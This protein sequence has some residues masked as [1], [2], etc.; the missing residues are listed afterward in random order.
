MVLG[1]EGLQRNDHEKQTS[2]WASALCA[3]AIPKT[4]LSPQL[5]YPHVPMGGRYRQVL[6]ASMGLLLE[7]QDV[8]PACLLLI[9]VL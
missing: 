4:P 3:L 9:P 2:P 6:L 1:T 5:H 7:T 8:L